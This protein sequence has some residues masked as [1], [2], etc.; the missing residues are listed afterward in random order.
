MWVWPGLVIPTLAHPISFEARAGLPCGLG[1]RLKSKNQASKIKNQI[2]IRTHGKLLLTGEYFVLDGALALA[3]PT[4]FGQHFSFQQAAQAQSFFWKAL[5]HEGEPWLEAHFD[6]KGWL[7]ESSD[8][9]SGE[10]LEQI[11]QYITRIHPGFWEEQTLSGIISCLDF[12]RFWGLGSSSTL[13]AALAQWANVNPFELLDA[14]LGGSGYD[15][16]CAQTTQPL[17]F[18]RRNNQASFVE[19]PYRPAF[20]DS[21]LLVYLGKK[22]DSR[23][24]IAHYRQMETDKEAWIKKISTLSLRFLQSQSPA[25][26]ALVMEQHESSISE[27]LQLPKVKDLYFS[28][29][30]G[31]VK[32][33]GAWGGD[34]VLACSTWP[35]ARAKAYFHNKGFD[36]V[37]AYRELFF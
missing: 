19:L 22:Q 10:L 35:P 16:A 34:F 5:N 9:K 13:I 32:S 36:T 6:A 28:D 21:L 8:R 7:L 29:F 18:Q 30:E 17:L 26:L 25:E 37:L 4:R 12:P 24:G 1:W 14:T 20:A 3:L 27:V 15:I 23:Q 11:F 33:L 31:A 2:D